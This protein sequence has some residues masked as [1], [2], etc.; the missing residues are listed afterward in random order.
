MIVGQNLT[1]SEIVLMRFLYLRKGFFMKKFKK[2]TATIL[3]AAMTLTLGSVPV[4]ADK[5][6]SPDDDMTLVFEWTTY[7]GNGLYSI[8]K[9]WVSDVKECVLEE[10]KPSEA[11][12]VKEFSDDEMTLISE[13]RIDDGEFYYIDKTWVSDITAV[14]R[15]NYN[16]RSVQRTREIHYNDNPDSVKLAEIYSYGRFCWNKDEN[17]VVVVE[18]QCLAYSCI[19]QEYPKVHNKRERVEDNCGGWPGK[20]YAVVDYAIELE[21]EKGIRQIYGI[22]IDV[23]VEGEPTIKN[24]NK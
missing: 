18:H 16:S 14:S 5:T 7:D 3:C 15:T 17:D 24:L 11:L 12:K 2:I 8:N 4:M 21:V 20:K 13:E 1:K 22:W 6:Q 19:S 9:T 10:I 23:N